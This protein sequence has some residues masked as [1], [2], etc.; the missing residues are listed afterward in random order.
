MFFQKLFGIYDKPV[1][2]ARALQLFFINRVVNFVRYNVTVTFSID[3]F[4][5][6]FCTPFT[7]DAVFWI[8]IDDTRFLIVR[9][10]NSI[11]DYTL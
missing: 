1:W 7:P 3:I 10:D 8:K 5:L 9:F 4:Q 2:F 11:A 6:L